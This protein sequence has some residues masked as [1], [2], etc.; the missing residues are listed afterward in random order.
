MADWAAPDFSTLSR[1]RKTCRVCIPIQR[2]QGCLHLLV[3]STG[4][5]MMGE[6]E[7]KLKKQGADCR[8]QWHKLHL[9]I[10]VQT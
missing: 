10:D 7:W 2:K 9:S 4:I 5:K 3:D 6:G 1:H 8:R